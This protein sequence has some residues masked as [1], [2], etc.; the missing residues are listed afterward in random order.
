MTESEAIDLAKRVAKAEGWAW[1][2]PARTAFSRPWFGKDKGKGRWVVFSNA[3][4][5][6]AIARVVIDDQT[7]AVL[8][9][10]YISR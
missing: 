8:D 1:I 3:I 4:G 2:E 5:F 10:G 6:G 9:K 7:G